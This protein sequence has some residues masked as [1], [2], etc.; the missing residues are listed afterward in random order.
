MATG[1]AVDRPRAAAA[2]ICSLREMR[3]RLLSDKDALLAQYRRDCVTLGKSISLVRGDEVRH[4]KALDIDSEGALV[5]EFS[6]G[7]TETVNS[8]EVSIRGMYGY[9]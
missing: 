5:V 7:I 4:G 6:P 9:V 3:M 2:M 1:T 8:G